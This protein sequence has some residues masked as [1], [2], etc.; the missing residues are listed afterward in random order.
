MARP[1]PATGCQACRR[2]AEQPVGDDATGRY[3]GQG[4]PAGGGPAGPGLGRT[5]SPPG[6]RHQQPGG[7]G[8]HATRPE[9]V[10]GVATDAA[11]GQQDDAPTDGHGRGPAGRRAR[12]EPP[13]P[14]AAARPGPAGTSRRP[15]AAPTDR[16]ATGAEEATPKDA[17][18]AH[19][20]R[21]RTAGCGPPPPWRCETGT[22]ARPPGG[23][24]AAAQPGSPSAPAGRRPP[25]ATPKAPTCG[26]AMTSRRRAGASGGSSPSA[27]ST[28]PSKWSRP[29]TARSA[30]T[31]RAAATGLVQ[32]R[33]ANP[34]DAPEGQ[35]DG[36]AHQREPVEGAGVRGRGRRRRASGRRPR[37]A[38]QPSPARGGRGRE[39]PGASARPAT[40]S[41]TSSA[42][43]AT[44]R[45]SD[46]MSVA[47]PAAGRRVGMHAEPDLLGH[48]HRR[49][50]GLAARR[51]AHSA[52]RVDR[53]ARARPPPRSRG[54]RPAP[55]PRPPA[56]T[57]TRS[58]PASTVVQVAGRRRR[59]AAMRAA[60][61]GSASPAR[62]RRG[63]IGRPAAAGR[64]PVAR[65]TRT[66]R[67]ARPPKHQGDTGVCCQRPRVPPDPAGVG[68][69][70]GSRIHFPPAF[71]PRG[72]VAMRWEVAPRS[73]LRDSPGIAPGS[74][75]Y[76]GD[77]SG[78]AW[79][80]VS[81]AWPRR[82]AGSASIVGGDGAR[83][84]DRPAQ[85]RPRQGQVVGRLRG[86]GPGLG[87]GLAGRGGP[88]REGRQVEDRASASWPT[89]S[90]S[91][92]TPSATASPGSRPTWTRRPPRA[93]TPGRWRPPSWRRATTTC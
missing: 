20:R 46:P 75:R 78:S 89:I 30:T 82:S 72:A 31:T 25:T 56:S 35:P 88:V 44:A 87:P 65:P 80:S 2:F 15:R 68:R 63:D 90:A 10:A 13:E 62:V 73:Q 67:C 16:P 42:T 57:S 14:P 28:R 69:S 45:L 66:C 81:T 71:Q 22:T 61:S 86:D 43:S 9:H 32:T 18:P 93:A 19:L 70:P 12:P 1:N 91:S 74:L 8:Q 27:L 29:V 55:C 77:G 59:W 23:R 64:R 54:R 3:R 51:T 50:A 49:G 33:V 41:S 52:R 34:P 76:A 40:T 17:R 6:R 7:L 47:K 36:G 58:A 4:R 5:R 53:E 26:S 37:P 39:R 85:H 11:A 24:P 38:R 48:H 92:G 83:R 21:G 60:N 79:R 84:I